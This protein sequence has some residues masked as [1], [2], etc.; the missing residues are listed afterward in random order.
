MVPTHYALCGPVHIAWQSIG[1]GARDLLFI[2][3]WV[4]NVEANWAF[5]EVA[6]FLGRLAGLGRLLTFDKRGTGLSDRVARMPTMGERVD[7]V[8]AV[9]DA[10]QARPVVIVG[11]SEGCTLAALFAAEHPDRCAG[12]VLY[13]GWARRTCAPDYPWAPSTEERERFL[14]AVLR[15]WGGPMDLGTL[16]PSLAGDADFVERFAAYLRASASPGAAHALARM[17]TY[18]DVRAALPRVRAPTLVMHRQGDRDSSIEEGRYL[19]RHVPGAT[20]EV[21]P[22]DDH[23]PFVGDP[24]SLLVAIE[25]FV[26]ALPAPAA[27]SGAPAPAPARRPGDA[28]AALTP[29]QRE[30][31]ELLAQGRSNKEIAG[32]LGVSEHT[33]HRHVADVLVRLSARTRAQAATLFAERLLR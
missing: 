12:L 23:W 30:V 14:E 21:L 19:A 29:R 25:R 31:L 6:T 2:P 16:A 15:D 11:A 18:V 33:V 10:A 26:R 17:N 8:R 22:G 24:E 13:G 28:V 9:L 5:P 1:A 4:S 3:G 32:L 7:D 27:T 20:F